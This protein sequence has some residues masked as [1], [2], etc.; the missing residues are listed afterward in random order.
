MDL[1]PREFWGFPYFHLPLL[2]DELR[3]ELEEIGKEMVM[4]NRGI[5]LYDDEKDVL[6]EAAVPGIDPED[7]EVTFD[8]DSRVL[9]IRAEAKKEA[10]EEKRKYYY[11]LRKSY[12][13]RLTLPSNVD[14]SRDPE[15]SYKN[16]LV[17]VKFMKSP[18]LAPK[19]IPIKVAK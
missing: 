5:S 19:K 11:K 6:V 2:W 10:G 4:T 8:K 17:I 18:A 14:I 16:G 1:I 7:I 13:Y 3:E 15:V 9:W 12:S